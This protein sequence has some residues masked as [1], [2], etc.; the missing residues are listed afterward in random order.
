MSCRP[1]VRPPHRDDSDSDLRNWALCYIT[2][3][4]HSE[5]WGWML[6]HVLLPGVTDQSEQC[7]SARAWLWTEWLLFLARGFFRSR[8]DPPP[9]RVFQLLSPAVNDRAP[10][11]VLSSASIFPP[12]SFFAFRKH[13]RNT[14]TWQKTQG[15][16][17]HWMFFLFLHQGAT[18]L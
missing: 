2:G 13:R 11:S 10:L 8:G 16:K 1:F 14:Q 5:S 7:R 3:F 9:V 17:A 12:S 15:F 18:R 4:I 6:G